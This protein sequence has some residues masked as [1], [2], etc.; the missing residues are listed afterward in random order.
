M[1]SLV[2]H[3][4]RELARLGNDDDFNRSVIRS[5][6]EFAKYGH[7]GSSAMYAIPLIGEL[8][9]FHNLTPLTDDPREW[10]EVGPNLW[11][12]ARRP[13]AF[14]D[15][16]G[17]TY[18]IQESVPV[19]KSE[20]ILTELERMVKFKPGLSSVEAI[21]LSPGNE[22][23]ILKFMERTKVPF[24]L[25]GDMEVLLGLSGGNNTVAKKTD[26]IVCKSAHEVFVCPN[27]AFQAIFVPY[28]SVIYEEEDG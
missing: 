7:S 25:I 12:S 6:E 17:K 19:H 3:A 14:S 4:E 26:W 27:N 10:N 15:D 8:L 5:I 9:Q 13:D 1:S 18:R 2:Q 22:A 23:A 16:G 21:Q 20:H 28:E 24:E 11:Q